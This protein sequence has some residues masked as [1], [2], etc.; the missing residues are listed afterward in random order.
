M[1]QAIQEASKAYGL[2][3]PNPAVGAVLVFNNK[4]IGKGFH[5]GSGSPHAEREALADCRNHGFDPA[6][7]TLYCT[8]EPCC[9]IRKKTLPCV[10]AVIQAKIKRLVVANRDPN[11]EVSGKG[12]QELLGAGIEIT[13]G[14]LQSEGAFLNRQFF[15]AMRSSRP[16]VVLKWAED[17]R[18]YIGLRNSP[19]P[20][21]SGEAS[22]RMV[23]LLRNSVQGILVGGETARHDKPQL[24]ARLDGAIHPELPK[25]YVL[26]KRG[27]TL[28]HGASS[29]NPAAIDELLMKIYEDGVQTLLVEGGRKVFDFFLKGQAWNE[30]YC[31]K[32]SKNLNGDTISAPLLPTNEAMFCHSLKIGEDT[33]THRLATMGMQDYQQIKEGPTPCL[34]DL[35]NAL[36]SS[37]LLKRKREQVFESLSK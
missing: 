36:E 22:R 9:H 37:Y 35:Y 11:P 18:G 1:A 7:S 19:T 34:L 14:V 27:E 16:W 12:L 5:Q 26:S 3:A 15:H 30:M 23:H 28:E 6:G 32:T 13:E 8:L 20:W 29:I 17:N 25:R 21:M 10:P 2:T 4:I 33:L 24:T 31:F